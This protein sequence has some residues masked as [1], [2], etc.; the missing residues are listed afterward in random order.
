LNDS[1]LERLFKA[2]DTAKMREDTKE[3]YMK[4]IIGEAEYEANLEDWKAEGL[5][6]GRKEGLAKGLAEGL[7]EGLT[8]GAT[9]NRHEVARKMKDEGLAPE[10][11]AKCTGI[12]VAEAKVL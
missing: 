11:I 10:I 4:S 9:E 7:A 3:S 12:S 6:E 5:E 8:K 2:A 1:L